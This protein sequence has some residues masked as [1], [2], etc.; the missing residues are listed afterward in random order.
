MKTVIRKGVFETNSSS[1]HSITLGDAD[2]L[3]DTLPL[4][5]DG[6]TL[7][8]NC[9][10]DFQWETQTY[11]DIQAKLA[12]CIA[13]QID[14]ELLESVLKRQTGAKVIKY[15]HDKSGTIDHQSNGTAKERLTTETAIRNF[16]FNPN[17]ELETDNDN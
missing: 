10:Y 12:Y 1:M 3:M 8:V 2:G 13:D 17:S 7:S 9:D 6:I 16:I 11:T 15:I 5:D 14:P 4:D